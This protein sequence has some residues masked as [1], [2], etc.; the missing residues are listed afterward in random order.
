MTPDP[1]VYGETVWTRSSGLAYLLRTFRIAVHP[2]KLV[3]V[4]GGIFFTLCWGTVLDLVWTGTGHRV[5]ADAIVA[6]VGGVSPTSGTQVGVFQALRTFETACIRDAIESIRYA[7][8]IG[9]VHAGKPV[10]MPPPGSPE[11]A[12]RGAFADVLLMGRGGVW[13][14]TEHWLFALLFVPVVILI[15]GLFGGGVCRMAAIKFARDETIPIKEALRYAWGKLLNG[16]FLAP[17]IP[18]GAC[19]VIGV[20]LVFGGMFLSIPW[21]GDVLGGLAFVLALLAGLIMA[22][23]LVGTVAGGSLFWPTVAVEDSDA[24]D[25]VQ[26]GFSYVYGR[27]LRAVWYALWLSVFASFG[28]LF[29][30]FV[31]WLSAA[32]THVCIGLGSGIFGDHAGAANKLSLLWSPPTFEALHGFPTGQEGVRWVAAGLIGLWVTLWWG[33]AWSFLGSFYFCGS[34]V[35]YFLL[36]R[37]VDGVE[38]SEVCE[39][40]E[41]GLAEP[42]G[43]VVVDTPVAAQAPTPTT[44]ESA[45]APVM[46]E[47][48]SMPSEDAPAA[49]PVEQDPPAPALTEEQDVARE[50]SDDKG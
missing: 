4:L 32:C 30:M 44:D 8:F 22:L 42:P 43:P 41:G 36:R 13:L 3:L 48:A 40:D 29:V 35:A 5:D 11:N 14:I 18:L 6:H 10:V 37:D 31:V 33:L 12:A 46:D 15:W 9:P 26:R 28:W 49:A 1:D 50:T 21:V 27:P 24:F 45:P 47:S 2:G 17:V 25:A 16:F 38:L 23:L 19:V 39:D 20:V 34:T 7:R